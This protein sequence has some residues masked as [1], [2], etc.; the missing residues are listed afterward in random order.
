MYKINHRGSSNHYLSLS[1]GFTFFAENSNINN[2]TFY[3]ISPLNLNLDIE[4]VET[5]LLNLSD[6]YQ[7]SG[8]QVNIMSLPSSIFSNREFFKNITNYSHFLNRIYINIQYGKRWINME[9]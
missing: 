4:S 5:K 6:L 1:E 8:I 9:K 3:L 2:S 7:S